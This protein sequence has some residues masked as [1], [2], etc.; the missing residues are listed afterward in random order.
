MKYLNYLMGNAQFCAI[1]TAQWIL[2]RVALR[3]RMMLVVN[4][5][6]YAVQTEPV[7]KAIIH[8]HLIQIAQL[9][10]AI[11]TATA[12]LMSIANSQLALVVA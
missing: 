12:V 9:T 3:V 8:L 2:V 11:Q 1:M 10:H 4:L 5:A 6:L 7:V